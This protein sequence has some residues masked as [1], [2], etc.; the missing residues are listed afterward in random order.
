MSKKTPGLFKRGEVWH[1]AK[2]ICGIRV[3]ESTGES[4]REDAERY[5]NHRIQEIRNETIYSQRKHWTF[6]D[7]ALKYLQEETKKSLNRDAVSIEAVM[8]YIQDLPLKQIHM[9][10][11]TPFIKARRDAGINPGTINRD[12]AVIRRILKLAARLWRDGNGNTWIDEAPLL[13]SL[14]CQPRKPYPISW[15]EQKRLLQELPD[16][17]ATMVLFAVNT[18]LREKEL[19]GLRWDEE[20]VDGRFLIPSHRCKITIDRIVPLNSIARSIVESQRGK[21]DKYV[22]VYKRMAVQRINGNAWREARKRAGLE[23]VRVHDLRHT[24]GRRLRASG[25]SFE[26]RQ[27]LLGHKS[28]RMT[29]HYSQPEI[30]NLLACVELLCDTKATQ[31]RLV[32]VRFESV[33]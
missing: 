17:L 30:D 2:T 8:P 24:F 28:G 29:T 27:D 20:V 1:I 23:C 21:N 7:A 12:L 10:T 32:P 22:F 19:T 26:D 4:E 11:L 3:R 5:L 16:H 18:G 9:G 13:Q 25:V 14:K 31:K 6:V 15:D 33:R